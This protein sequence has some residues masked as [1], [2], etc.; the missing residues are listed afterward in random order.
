MC[1][2]VLASF[3]FFVVVLH[4]A[5]LLDSAD[6]LRHFFF[7]VRVEHGI[8]RWRRRTG[9]D[10]VSYVSAVSAQRTVIQVRHQFVI[11]RFESCDTFGCD[12]RCV[13]RA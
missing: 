4:V 6:M 10:V 13:V 9:S 8:G 1:S 3:V 5:F 11:C 12:C 7:A 2:S